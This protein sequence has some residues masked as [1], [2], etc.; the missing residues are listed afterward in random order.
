[1][2]RQA[3]TGV[4]SVLGV[5]TLLMALLAY[6][7]P[8]AA[9]A[10]PRATGGGSTFETDG[11]TERSTFVFN[12][13]QLPSGTVIGH[14]VYHFRLDGFSVMMD[15]N[16]LNIVASNRAIISGTITHVTGD[17]P[18]IPIGTVGVFQV[19]DNGEGDG[20]PPDR[21]GDLTLFANPARNCFNR[22]STVPH[23]DVT[24]NIQV[25]P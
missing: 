4:R 17:A 2:K 13:I 10:G 6:A 23:L 3:M 15:I 24:G 25:Q 22:T 20:A 7:P 19:E 1:M 11:T 16:C 5:S 8:A 14:L 9:E 21:V 18:P 12:A